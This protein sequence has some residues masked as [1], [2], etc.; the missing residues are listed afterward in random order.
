MAKVLKETVT[1][2]ECATLL[3]LSIY[4]IRQLVSSGELT[5]IGKKDNKRLLIA[6]TEV[7]SIVKMRKDKENRAKLAQLKRK[8][9]VRIKTIAATIKL[10]ESEKPTG[11]QNVVTILRG[12]H[13]KANKVPKASSDKAVE[14]GT[15]ESI[16][17]TDKS[18]K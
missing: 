13:E 18:G 6:K 11:W 14:K 12:M 8:E 5:V 2:E 1:L 17:A 9:S 16:A 10:L 4:R 7:E 3:E 15:S